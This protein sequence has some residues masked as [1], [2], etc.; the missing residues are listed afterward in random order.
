MESKAEQVLNPFKYTLSNQARKR[1]KWMY[2]LFY[3]CENNVSKAANKV[4]VSR[5][6]LSKLKTVFEKNN[7]CAL[8]LEPKSKAPHDT[9]NRQRISKYVEDKILLV[10]GKYP[11][12]GEEKIVRILYRDYKIKTCKNTV[13]RYLHKHHK[14]D[15]LISARNKKAWQNKKEKE[16]QKQVEL[17]VKYRPPRQIKDW[18]P[19]ALI[20]KDMKLVP[21]LNLQDSC[22]KRIKDNFWFQHTFKDSFTRIRCLGLT[23]ESY[24]KNAVKIYM[25]TKKE[26]PFKMASMNTDRGGENEKEF[27]EQLVKDSVIHFYSREGTPTDNPRVERSHLTDQKEFYDQGKLYVSFNKQKKLLEEWNYAYNYI[28]PHQALAYLT[29]MEFYEVW[30]KNPEQAYKIVEEY[31][32][33]LKKQRTRLSKSRRLNRKEQIDKIMKFI[34]NKLDNINIQEHSLTTHELPLTINVS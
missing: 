7:K 20:E 8:S 33:Y 19:G 32:E 5:E 15:P 14:I 34:E 29:P 12:W 31:Q 22:S 21:K 13:N 23:R 17:K 3:E 1:L 27:N 2:V 11:C 18:K 9:S 25:H 10:R 26:F 24:S 4:G 28:R 16:E 6:W 30:K